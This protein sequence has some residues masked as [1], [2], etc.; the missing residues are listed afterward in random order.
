[1]LIQAENTGQKEYNCLQLRGWQ[2]STCQQDASMEAY[3]V[4]LVGYKTSREEIFNL[5]QEVY[6]LKRTPEAIPG[7][8]DEA[9][10]TCQEILD[11]LKEC[12]WHRQGPAHLEQEPR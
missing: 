4:D 5:Y 10:K 9:E 11:S 6:Q 1:M 12:L 2:Q 8:P 7:D 3:T